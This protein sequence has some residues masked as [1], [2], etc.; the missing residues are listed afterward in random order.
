M[1]LCSHQLKT[2]TM[3]RVAITTWSHVCLTQEIK[4]E[5]STLHPEDVVTNLESY[6]TINLLLLTIG[7]ITE[8]Y[9]ILILQ[10]IDY[11]SRVYQ[12]LY[13]HNKTLI[14]CGRVSFLTFLKLQKRLYHTNLYH[15]EDRGNPLN[16]LIFVLPAF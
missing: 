13:Q 14:L 3:S 15:I 10:M 11:Y 1:K 12:N 8:T 5:I 9:P 4:S 6:T 7:R 2:L 16:Y